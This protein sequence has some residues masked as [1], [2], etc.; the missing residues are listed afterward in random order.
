MPTPADR[1][2]LQTSGRYPT[3]CQYQQLAPAIPSSKR[4]AVAHGTIAHNRLPLPPIRSPFV[5]HSFPV[6]SPFVSHWLPFVP[7]GVHCFP[8]WFSILCGALS[9]SCPMRHPAV[10]SMFR[11]QPEANL[12]G[13]LSSGANHSSPEGQGRVIHHCIAMALPRSSSSCRMRVCGNGCISDGTRAIFLRLTAAN[14]RLLHGPSLMTMAFHWSPLVSIGLH[15]Y[16]LVSIGLYCL[17]SPSVSFR[18][19]QMGPTY[20]LGRIGTDP[21]RI[22]VFQR[23]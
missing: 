13:C 3:R 1:R 14:T 11:T 22:R 23:P 9:N 20:T 15:W 2:G 18:F 17:S 8:L 7:I 21:R 16:S 6:R 12:I 4:S 5:P 19:L 10:H